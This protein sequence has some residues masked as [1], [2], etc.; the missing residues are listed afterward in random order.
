MRP[1][2]LAWECVGQAGAPVVLLHSLATHRDIWRLQ[3]PAWSAAF[4]LVCID[5][6]GHGSSP[7]P[8]APLTLD[9]QAALVCT[10][11]DQLGIER[12]AVVGLSWGGMVAQAMA[13]KAPSRVGSLVLAHTSA[14][15]APALREIWQ[16]RIDDAA[17]R[18]IDAQV[19]PTLAR[20][21]T[22]AFIEASPMTM[23]WVARQIRATSPEGY[24]SAIRAIQALDHLEGLASID[25]PTLVIAGEHDAAVP[26]QA[27]S[28]MAARMP[29][30]ELQVLGG[31]GHIGNVQQPLA[32]TEA[33]G[34]FLRGVGHPA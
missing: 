15:T 6:P 21:F 31:A 14:H 11:L 30:A 34:R 2:G 8:E 28:A 24:A 5:L 10:V 32:F 1:G 29:R 16:A 20:W 18:G 3:L 13:L 9:D 27:A 22:P 26:P 4:R 33:V 23:A 7:A 19:A 25:V 12:A 17:Q